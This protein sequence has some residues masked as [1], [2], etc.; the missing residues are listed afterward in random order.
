[1]EV[2]LAD[3]VTSA[4]QE[5]KQMGGRES[6][7]WSIRWQS[8]FTTRAWRRALTFCLEHFIINGVHKYSLDT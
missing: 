2:T 8:Q 6:S 5:V 3:L 1:M 4:G 7:L